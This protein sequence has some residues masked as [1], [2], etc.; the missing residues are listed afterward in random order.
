MKSKKRKYNPKNL[1]RRSV[2]SGITAA[3]AAP[4]VLK[5]TRAYAANPT[6]KIGHVSP[7]TG[8]LAGFAEADEHVLADIQKLFSAGLPFRPKKYGCQGQSVVMHGNSLTSA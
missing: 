3:A 5:F 6:I 7:R 1:T 8:P 4:A 2:L